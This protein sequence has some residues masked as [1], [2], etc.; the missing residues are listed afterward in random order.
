[1]RNKLL[2]LIAPF[3]LLPGIQS[4]EAQTGKSVLDGVYTADQARRGQSEYSEKC[5]KCHGGSEPDA[6]PIFGDEFVDRWREDTLAP[7]LNFMRT[8]MPGDAPGKFE[9]HVYVDVLAYMLEESGYNAGSAELTVAGVNTI[10]LV[11]PNGPQP[12]PN[13]AL[14]ST[15]GCLTPGSGGSWTLTNVG[16]PSRT[17]EGD[18]LNAEELSIGK[19]KTLGS[20]TFAL[21]NLDLLEKFNPEDHKGQKMLVKGVYSRQASGE[22]LS[23]TAIET[24]APTCTP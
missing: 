24:V 5:E 20:Q 8:R 11:G 23:V 16:K 22:R 4:L 18:H 2:L 9:E 10:Q 7:L 19:T 15:V 6:S 13:Q 1:M 12:L 14:I 17:K 3:L 21:R